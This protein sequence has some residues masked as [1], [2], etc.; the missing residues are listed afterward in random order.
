MTT[1]KQKKNICCT[2][3]PTFIYLLWDGMMFFGTDDN[4][5]DRLKGIKPRW[6][7]RFLNKRW[8]TFN[9]VFLGIML[10]VTITHYDLLGSVKSQQMNKKLLSEFNSPVLEA[11][12]FTT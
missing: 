1:K 6:Y 10:Y 7:D 12:K 2:I 11:L 5:L 4:K 9:L 3:F 8:I